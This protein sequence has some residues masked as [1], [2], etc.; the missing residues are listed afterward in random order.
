MQNSKISDTVIQKI[1]DAGGKVEIV[2]VPEAD[3]KV[4][5]ETLFQNG[6]SD[7]YSLVNWLLS[8]SK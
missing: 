3:H 7:P 4:I 8:K 2:E 6:K 1:N 5:S